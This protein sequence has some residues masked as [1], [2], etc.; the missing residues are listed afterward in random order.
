[1]QDMLWPERMAREPDPSTSIGVPSSSGVAG[2]IDVSLE[3]ALI[4]QPGDAVEQGPEVLPQRHARGGVA[5]LGKSLPDQSPFEW[6][7]LHVIRGMRD[8]HSTISSLASD[9][10]LSFV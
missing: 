6:G 2:T 5:I 1:M 9:R 3:V 8:F 10:G 7:E 4:G